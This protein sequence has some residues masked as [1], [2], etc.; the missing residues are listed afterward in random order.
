MDDV[1]VNG[2]GWVVVPA[3]QPSD[4]FVWDPWD[5]NEVVTLKALYRDYGA[6][7]CGWLLSK[8]PQALHAKVSNLN[9]TRTPLKRPDTRGG[10]A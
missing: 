4:G 10:V 2:I 7:R 8:T 3:N 9:L 1:F 5:E 6:K